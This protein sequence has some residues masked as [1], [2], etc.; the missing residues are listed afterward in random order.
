MIDIFQTFRKSIY[1]L[2][3]ET[4][5]QEN[6]RPCDPANCCSRAYTSIV[7]ITEFNAFKL[8]ALI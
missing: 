6:H 1:M 7:S 8:I 3:L 4:I 5:D 2:Y